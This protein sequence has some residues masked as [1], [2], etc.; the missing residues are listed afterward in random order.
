[1]TELV[2]KKDRKT[3]KICPEC[4]GVF[5]TSK[6]YKKFCSLK[7]C[8]TYSNR[9][10]HKRYK[11][12]RRAREKNAPGSFKMEDFFELIKGLKNICPSCGNCIRTNCF[13]VDHIMPLSKGGSNYISNIQPLCYLCNVKKN[14]KIIN[15]LH[16]QFQQA[17]HETGRCS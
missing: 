4:G 12:N 5:V 1:V 8:Y 7:C 13:S 14:T 11:H 3:E 15:F 6:S 9:R 17:P 16:H 10:D 2:W